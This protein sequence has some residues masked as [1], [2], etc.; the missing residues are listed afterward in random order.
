MKRRIYTKG[1]LLVLGFCFTSFIKLNAQDTT[2]HVVRDLE[3]W[4]SARFLYKVNKKLKLKLSENLRLDH[5]SSQFNNWFTEFGVAYEPIKNL[6]LEFETRY[7]VNAKKSGNSNYMRFFYALS[8]EKEI[9]RLNLSGR[10]AYQNR[11]TLGSSVF[12]FAIAEYNWR[13]QLKADYNIK[14][15]KLD[16][17]LSF[18]GFRENTI[19]EP[20]FDKYRIKLS[21]DYNFSKAKLTPFVAFERELNEE[22]P[23][24]ATIIGLNFT[25]ALKRKKNEKE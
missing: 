21:T 1:L 25:Y 4:T 5:N 19:D 24:N 3:S 16:P 6:T 15:W 11:N 18:E 9:G 14:D 8:Y 17:E 7:G 20:G 23:L 12:D 2:V 22:Y 10:A 13:Y